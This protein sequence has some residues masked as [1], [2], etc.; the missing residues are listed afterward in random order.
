[1]NFIWTFESLKKL[2]VHKDSMVKVWA[3]ERLSRLFPEQTGDVAITF[4]MDKNDAVAQAAITHFIT[5]PEEKYADKILEAYRNSR[6]FRAGMLANAIAAVQDT[7]LI[8]V[9]REKYGLYG[10]DDPI[11]YAASIFHL[12]RL[13]TQESKRIA[14]NALKLR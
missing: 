8:Q 2:L 4:V 5:Y 9:F 14:E 1:M 10:Q 13:H 7:R 6:D 11:G 12:A 3:I